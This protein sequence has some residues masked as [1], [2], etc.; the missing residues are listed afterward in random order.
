MVSDSLEQGYVGR[1]IFKEWGVSSVR[2]PNTFP[3]YTCNCICSTRR[4]DG[5]IFDTT[6]WAEE[7]CYT[8]E[9]RKLRQRNATDVRFYH[10]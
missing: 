9:N 8:T 6:G 5:G 7:E 10:T 4:D 2:I 3:V 1:K